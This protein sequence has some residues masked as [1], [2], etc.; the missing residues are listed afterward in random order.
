VCSQK[1]I[2]N[3]CFIL[4]KLKAF[5]ENIRLQEVDPIMCFTLE[6][7]TNVKQFCVGNINTSE[8]INSVLQGGAEIGTTVKNSEQIL[9]GKQVSGLQ[10]LSS[11][12]KIQNLWPSCATSS[13]YTGLATVPFYLFQIG[14]LRSWST[15]KL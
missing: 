13:L 2:T 10:F 3:K 14:Q 9:T 6:Q 15:I 12:F 7:P 1:S 4:W 5:L 11:L 8:D